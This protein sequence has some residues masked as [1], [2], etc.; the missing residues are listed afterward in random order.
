[1]YLL[2][3]CYINGVFVTLMTHIIVRWNA[4]PLDQLYTC[5]INDGRTCYICDV[6]VVS[7]P[8][9]NAYMYVTHM[10]Y[11]I[12]IRRTCYNNGVCVT[13]MACLLHQCWI[14]YTNGVPTYDEI[15]Y[16]YLNEYCIAMFET[17]TIVDLWFIEKV[18]LKSKI[19]WSWLRIDTKPRLGLFDGM[20]CIVFHL[21]PVCTR[22]NSEQTFVKWNLFWLLSRVR[23]CIPL[24]TLLCAIGF[25]KKSTVKLHPSSWNVSIL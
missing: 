15:K 18:T 6:P 14:N 12:H 13:K 23:L 22:L 1:M 7:M 10:A 17:Q 9:S 11:M 3:G 16:G 25:K 8:S 5:Y 20:L 2:V 19:I 4:Y 24:G 21:A